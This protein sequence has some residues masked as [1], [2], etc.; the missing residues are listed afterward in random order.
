MP[1]RKY[2]RSTTKRRR[3]TTSR[4]PSKRSRSTTRRRTATYKSRKTRRSTVAKPIMGAHSMSSSSSGS[5]SIYRDPFSTVNGQPKIPDGK[6]IMSVGSRCQVA[7]ELLNKQSGDNILH[8]LLYPGATQGMVVWGDA[9][10]IAERDFTAFQYND[11]MTYDITTPYGAGTNPITPGGIT[12]NDNINSWRIVSQGLKLSLLNTGEEN[13]GWWECIRYKDAFQASNFGFYSGDNTTQ[14][15]TCVY[16]PDSTLKATLAA[17][18][19]VNS[20]TY[21]SGALSDIDKAKFLLQ[22][23]SGDHDFRKLNRSYYVDDTDMAAVGGAQV[24]MTMASSTPQNDLI[25]NAL[26]DPAHD[27]IYIRIHCRSNTGASTNNGSRLLYH[28]VANHEVVYDEDQNEHKFMT[29]ADPA[30]EAFLK[31]NERKRKQGS[32]A[33]QIG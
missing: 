7:G 12:S 17:K 15:A 19:L 25:H 28:L 5:L 33:M 18:N 27:A 14:T 26:I 11:H 29:R 10:G 1:V 30:R 32:G 8:V 3:R 31:E 2:S 20:P 16:G 21:C 24:Y 23:Q 4:K 6:A 22:P 9:S 13:D